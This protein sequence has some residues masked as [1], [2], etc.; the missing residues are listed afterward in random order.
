MPWAASESTRSVI[1]RAERRRI[2]VHGQGKLHLVGLGA[3]RNGRQQQHPRAAAR[4][5]RAQARLAIAS[6]WNVSVP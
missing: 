2:Q 3:V 1:T 5:A 6:T 4:C